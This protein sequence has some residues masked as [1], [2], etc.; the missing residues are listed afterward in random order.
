MQV[1]LSEP[2]EPQG[3]EWSESSSYETQALLRDPVTSREAIMQQDERT[4]TL[5]RWCTRYTLGCT[6]SL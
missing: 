4:N 3:P 6:V 1:I 2:V 5:L